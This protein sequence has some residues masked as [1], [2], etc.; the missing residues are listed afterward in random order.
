MHG[1]ESSKYLQWT[2]YYERPLLAGVPT[3][4]CG[5]TKADANT[6]PPIAKN[7]VTIEVFAT[8]CGAER[9]KKCVCE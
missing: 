4:S 3:V 7:E 8:T 1:L 9:P 5:G 6:V 2:L